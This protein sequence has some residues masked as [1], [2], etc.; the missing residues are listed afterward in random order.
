M[1]SHK[2]QQ[3]MLAKEEDSSPGLR[4]VPPMLPRC[5]PGQETGDRTDRIPAEERTVRFG[6]AEPSQRR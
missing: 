6:F 5:N 3:D 1:A 4:C 2:R